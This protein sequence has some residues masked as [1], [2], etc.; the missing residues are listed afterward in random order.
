[1][2][3]ASNVK[4]EMHLILAIDYRTYGKEKPFPGLDLQL[5]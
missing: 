2:G 5:V 3:K 1:M 4:A